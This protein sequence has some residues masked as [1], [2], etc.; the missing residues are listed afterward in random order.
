MNVWMIPH[1]SA[2]TQRKRYV[3]CNVYVVIILCSDVQADRR[4]ETQTHSK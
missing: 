3:V 4:H 1:K 2:T